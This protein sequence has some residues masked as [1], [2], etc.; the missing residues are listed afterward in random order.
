MTTEKINGVEFPQTD[1]VAAVLS[2]IKRIIDAEC[3]VRLQVYE[4]G[5]WAVRYGLSDYDQDHRGF[6]GAAS[7]S[8][9]DESDTLAWVASDLIDQAADACACCSLD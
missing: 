5:T 9:D 6:W 1:D 4:D 3:D 2:K 8:P 7:I